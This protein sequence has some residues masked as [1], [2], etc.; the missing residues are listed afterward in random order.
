M[1]EALEHMTSAAVCHRK[2]DSN[3]ARPDQAFHHF[4]DVEKALGYSQAVLAGD[5]LY[6]S[7][8]ISVDET[9]AIIGKGDMGRQIETIYAILGSVL[10]RHDM[11][12]R[13]VVKET[14]FLTDLAAFAEARGARAAAYEAADA[15][16]SASTAVEVKALFSPDAMIEIDM[17]AVR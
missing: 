6:V 9:L 14:L 2:G 3:M 10:A 7:G 12:L 16:P 13:N 1:M 5:T 15:Y 17:I 8:M 11:T 4:P